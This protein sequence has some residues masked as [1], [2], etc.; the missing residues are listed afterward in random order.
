MK[1]KNRNILV[2]LVAILAFGVVTVA[3]A[4]AALP[5]FTGSFPNKITISVKQQFPAIVFNY[6]GQYDYECESASGT[7][8]ITGPKALTAKF[9]LKGCRP[10]GGALCNTIGAAA[11]EIKTEELKSALVY[12]SKSTKEVG[13]DFN[14]YEGTGFKNLPVFALFGCNEGKIHE[15]MRGGFIAPLTQTGTKTSSYTLKVA[16]SNGNQKPLEYENEAGKK[17]NNHLEATAIGGP[18]LYKVGVESRSEVKLTTALET[19]VK[20]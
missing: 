9:T 13:I 1:S 14:Q 8:T 17:I 2:A 11:G 5:E 18:E 6:A 12:I 7:G 15:T 20:A 3:S 19:E 16:Q 10:E 4:S